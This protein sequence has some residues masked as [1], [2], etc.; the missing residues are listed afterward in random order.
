MQ[1][2]LDA[3]D[4]HQTVNRKK[5][6]QNDAQHKVLIISRNY[7]GVIGAASALNVRISTPSI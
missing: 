2:L 6:S 4:A 5:Q 3:T 1:Y 7:L